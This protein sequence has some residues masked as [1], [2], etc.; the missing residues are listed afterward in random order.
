MRQLAAVCAAVTCKSLASVFAADPCTSYPSLTVTPPTCTAVQ[1]GSNTPHVSHTSSILSSWIVIVGGYAISTGQPVTTNTVMLF[2]PAAIPAS[3]VIPTLSVGYTVPKLIPTSV[4]PGSRAEHSSIV[5]DDAIV[6]YGGQNTDFMNDMWRLCVGSSGSSGRWDE[7]TPSMGFVPSARKGHSA[8]V[9]ATNSTTMVA[10]VFGGMLGT[11]YQDTNDLYFTIISKSAGSTACQTT[12]PIVLWQRVTTV[13][14]STGGRPSPR[15]YH[16]M[17]LNPSSSASRFSNCAIVYG[18]QSTVD[19]TIMDDMWSLCPEP[20]TPSNTPVEQQT[21]VWTQLAPSGTKMPFPRFGHAAIVPIPNRFIIWGGSYRFPNDYLNDAW[22][23]DLYLQRWIALALVVDGATP[24]SPRRFHSATYT[25][26]RQ[27]ILLGGLDRYSLKDSSAIQCTYTS[28]QCAA[29]SVAMFCN[30]TDEIVCQPCPAGYFAAEGARQCGVCPSGTYSTDGSA[31]CTDCPMGTYNVQSAS[32]SL[33]SCERCPIGTFSTSIRAT[34]YATC[35]SC[36][37]GSFSNVVGST[38]CTPCAAGTFSSANASLC[39]ACVA[40]TFSAAAASSCSNCAPGSYTPF[41]SMSSCLACPLGMYSNA[42]AAQCTACPLGTASS[43]VMGSLADCVACAAGS[44]ADSL[45]QST[46]TLCPDG[47]AS[48]VVGSSSRAS[49]TLCPMGTFSK[50]IKSTCTP[51]PR[52]TYAHQTGLAACFACPANTFTNGSTLATSMAACIPCPVGTQLHAAS[53]TCTNCPPGTR[54]NVNT[55][56]CVLCPPGSFTATEDDAQAT[57]CTAC[58]PMQASSSY[59]SS[60]C[61]GC[62]LGTYSSNQWSTC[63]ACATPCPIGRN[64]LVCSNQGTCAYGGCT[65]NSNSYGFACGSI[66]QLAATTTSGVIYFATSNNTILYDNVTN[67]VT[68]QREGGC[69]GALSVVV[70]TGGGNATA[71][72][73]GLSVGWT[74]TVTFTD[75]QVTKTL[76]LPLH[77]VTQGCASLR[78]VLSDPYPSQVSSNVSATDGANVVI[79]VQATT[80]ATTSVLQVVATTTGYNISIAVSSTAATSTSVT[81]PPLAMPSINTFLYFDT[82]VDLTVVP[83]V[84]AMLAALEAQFALKDWRFAHN[85]NGTP[86]FINDAAGLYTRLNAIASVAATPFHGE[87]L[88]ATYLS[89]LPWAPGAL[90]QVVVF[91]AATAIAASTS[92][93]SI[94][95]ECVQANA[96][97]LFFTSTGAFPTMSALA[98]NMGIGAIRSYTPSTFVT[99]LGQLLEAESPVGFYV[100]SNPYTLVQA[101][102]G[103]RQAVTLSFRKA[104]AMDPSPI[105]VVANALGLGVLQLTLFT[106]LSSCSPPPAAAPTWPVSTGWIAPYSLTTDLAAQWTL[107][108]SPSTQTTLVAQS[109]PQGPGMTIQTSSKASYAQMVPVHLQPAT[110][111]IVRAYVKGSVSTGSIELVLY[112]SN[113]ATRVALPLLTVNPSLPDWQFVYARVILNDTTMSLQLVVNTST[114]LQVANLGMYPEPAFA[115]QCGPGFFVHKGA[116]QRCP[117]GFSCGGGVLSACTKQTYSFGAFATCKPCLPGWTCSGGLALPCPKGTYTTDATT[118]VPCPAGFKC[119]QGQK[120][121]CAAGTFAPGNSSVCSLC[122]PGTYASSGGAKDCAVCPPGYTSN[123]RRDHCIPCAAGTTSTQGEKGFRCKS[124]E[125]NTFALAGATTCTS[126]P[127]AHAS[128]KFMDLTSVVSRGR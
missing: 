60:S 34:S 29:G 96:I 84:P 105:F 81:L 115:C 27:L 49:C 101:A 8:L 3:V 68:L 6:I 119:F 10:M 59:G 35:Q 114:T 41:P 87:F 113:G 64:G 94:R 45:G 92:A 75:Q 54:R 109:S 110:P 44:Y 11:T 69:R 86:A 25:A 102:S 57:Q 30:A 74:A 118:C 90:R 125:K 19:N 65:C 82:N 52:S 99:T 46:C 23:Y 22:E 106:S 70:S 50:A 7:V 62:T 116:C 32:P 91:T 103:T 77:T 40:G 16:T 104:T 15:S 88:N 61:D 67:S 51:C 78:L 4:Q 24:I 121:S 20:S 17:V 124:C 95:Q 76:T 73:G 36:P 126:C 2:D 33:A 39:T 72:N 38:G 122:L 12:R 63:L 93:A 18:G 31:N 53:G 66:V 117:S 9:Y 97:P 85:M 127:K 89:S 55:S 71:T 1:V 108:T 42:T 120:T 21:F 14:N 58:S 5:W 28:S 100:V 26:Q 80:V 128:C 48:S 56:G 37:A 123:Y 79:L 83:L 13:T 111:L 98:S 112:A 43:R 107:Q 47:S